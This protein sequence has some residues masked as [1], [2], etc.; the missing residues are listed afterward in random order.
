MCMFVCLCVPYLCLFVC[1]ILITLHLHLHS[2]LSLSFFRDFLNLFP[3]HFPYCL[4]I[5]LAHLVQREAGHLLAAGGLQATHLHHH[6]HQQQSMIQAMTMLTAL[7]VLLLFLLLMRMMMMKM[8]QQQQQQLPLR[9]SPEPCAGG[10][11]CC[12]E[13]ACA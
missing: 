3:F 7:L 9:A 8:W 12:P 13:R 1:L 2:F 4:S 5:A 6:H 11:Q 10:T